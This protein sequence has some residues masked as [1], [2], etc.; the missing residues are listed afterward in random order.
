[1]PRISANTITNGPSG[2]LSLSSTAVD[3]G[4]AWTNLD[5]AEAA[6]TAAETINTKLTA[7]VA[8]PA[9]ALKLAALEEQTGSNKQLL[10][11]DPAAPTGR[12]ISGVPPYT[13]ATIGDDIVWGIPAAHSLVVIRSDATV[14]T[15]GSVYF[16]SDQVAVRATIR[17]G[18]GFTYPAAVVKI[19]T[20]P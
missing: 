1:M 5:W 13:S 10:S 12:V 8:N 2:L 9:I 14:V 3:A 16:P 15:D 18:V 19:A 4:D 6:K 11:A 7:F 17:V 20:T